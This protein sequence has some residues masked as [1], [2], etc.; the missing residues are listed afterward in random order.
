MAIWSSTASSDCL[1]NSKLQWCLVI[2][3]LVAHV[4]A[5]LLVST[6]AYST[7]VQNIDPLLIPTF[8][9]A[10]PN[11]VNESTPAPIVPIANESRGTD[12]GSHIVV[13]QFPMQHIPRSNSFASTATDISASNVNFI[14]HKNSHEISSYTTCLIHYWMFGEIDSPFPTRYH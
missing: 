14:H 12:T 6:F 4:H 2:F 7:C 10:Y 13:F 9:A 8:D 1:L 5:E 11:V 3:H